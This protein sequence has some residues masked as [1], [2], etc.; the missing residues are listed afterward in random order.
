MNARSEGFPFGTNAE[1]LPTG[2]AERLMARIG[3]ALRER[4]PAPPAAVEK[5]EVDIDAAM[6]AIAQAMARARDGA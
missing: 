6:K 3:Q 2:E 5:P 1:P 4:Q